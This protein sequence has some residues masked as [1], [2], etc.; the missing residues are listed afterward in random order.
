MSFMVGQ[1][2]LCLAGADHYETLCQ[3]AESFPVGR[4]V[5]AKTATA[6]RVFNR[7]FRITDSVSFLTSDSGKLVSAAMSLFDS[8][9][10]TP[11]R[12][13]RSLGD[14]SSTSRRRR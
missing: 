6:V 1:G 2:P 7:N 3:P 13:R 11:A 10:P 4:I 12:T 8:A 9:R 5:A 14:R